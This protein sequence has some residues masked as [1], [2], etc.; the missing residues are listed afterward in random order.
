MI[1]YTRE[2]IEEQKSCQV[3]SSFSCEPCSQWRAI[4]YI[5][6]NSL[7]HPC[8]WTHHLGSSHHLIAISASFKNH[9]CFRWF[10]SS[11]PTSVE[12]SPSLPRIPWR[13]SFLQVT[14]KDP[15]FFPPSALPASSVHLIASDSSLE[16]ITCALPI[17]FL[18]LH[19]KQL[20][21][22]ALIISYQ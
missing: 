16:V 11:G 7:I 5:Q 12:F 3:I 2:N 18:S 9:F 20:S 21:Q 6:W 1:A 8:T 19:Y 13:I 17:F 4:R 10:Q 14:N 15:P 22:H